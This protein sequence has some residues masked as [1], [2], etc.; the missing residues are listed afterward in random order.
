M[1][2]AIVAQTQSKLPSFHF[3]NTLALFAVDIRALK[4][5]ARIP[6]LHNVR[7][8]SSHCPCQRADY[9]TSQR[10][11]SSAR[12]RMRMRRVTWSI[13][14]QY[15]MPVTVLVKMS[16]SWF[17]SRKSSICLK[18][19]SAM[20]ASVGAHSAPELR[21]ATYIV[22]CGAQSLMTMQSQLTCALRLSASED[23]PRSICL[24]CS[25]ATPT[26]Q[27][28]SCPFLASWRSRFASICLPKL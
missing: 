19:H 4:V 18:I 24:T 9:A 26:Y 28:W 21:Y 27:N 2:N 3:F 5:A 11:L 13:R 15:T 6:C 23:T 12:P 17:L 20:K 1:P 16:F 10:V 7:V 25:P 8:I 22:S 14:L